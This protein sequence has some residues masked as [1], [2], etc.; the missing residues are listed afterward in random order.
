M[1]TPRPPRPG[2]GAGE[3]GEG[4][5]PAGP[6]RSGDTRGGTQGARPAAGWELGHL[7]AG[8]L[9]TAALGALAAPPVW[10]LR[11]GRAALWVLAGLA[12]VAAFFSVSA[13]AVAWAGR[14][15]D[16]LTL[17]VA[18]TTYLIKIV[19]LGVLLVTVR[20]SSALDA[21][22]LAWSV[23]GGTVVWTG[24]HV[25]RVWTARLYYVDP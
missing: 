2:P 24:V 1:G 12:I 21:P 4:R 15:A 13:L 22:A 17:P 18:L 3:N 7:R 14:I 25:R 20:D 16:E 11:G 8:L 23:L 9:V 5:L 10:L 6:G 19:L